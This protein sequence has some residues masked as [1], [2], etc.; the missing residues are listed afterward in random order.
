MGIYSDVSICCNDRRNSH[1]CPKVSQRLDCFAIPRGRYSC[2]P[3][4]VWD[5]EYNRGLIQAIEHVQP[6]LRPSIL[7]AL[8]SSEI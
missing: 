3:D 4:E 2:R 5:I 1:C 7:K 6:E 8:N